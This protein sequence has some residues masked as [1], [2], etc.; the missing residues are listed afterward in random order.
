MKIKDFEIIVRNIL[1][2]IL[3]DENKYIELL[4][5]IGNNYKHDFKNQVSIYKY[6]K[7]ANTCANFDT[8]KKLHRKVIA[9]TKGIPAINSASKQEIKHLFDITQTIKNPLL[10]EKQIYI[11]KIKNDDSINLLLEQRNIEITNDISINLMNVLEYESL[12]ISNTLY[13]KLSNKEISKE[14]FNRFIDISLKATY[15][16]RIYKYEDLT[17]DKNSI[18]RMLNLL[19]I[20]D[21]FLVG[22]T[23]STNNKRLLL[24][25]EKLEK[26]AD[27]NEYIAYNETNKELKS[28]KEITHEDDNI[29][30]STKIQNERTRSNNDRSDNRGNTRAIA[31]RR[32]KIKR[33]VYK[34]STRIHSGVRVQRLRRSRSDSSQNGRYNTRRIQER[35]G[36]IW[37]G[38]I[39]ISSL[40]IHRGRLGSSTRRIYRWNTNKPSIESPK[41]LLGMDTQG[42]AKDEKIMGTNTTNASG[43]TTKVGGTI[44]QPITRTTFNGERY[45]LLYLDEYL[46]NKGNESNISLPFS[47]PEK[48]FEGIENYYY[49]EFEEEDFDIADL[50]PYNVGMA[51]TTTPDEKHEIQFNINLIDLTW[52][53]YVDMQKI[54][55]G[56]YNDYEELYQTIISCPFDE[57]VHINEDLLY[58]ETGLFIDDEGNFAED[59]IEKEYHLELEFTESK[60]LKTILENK[61]LNDKELAFII[62]YID[63]MQFRHKSHELLGGYYKTYIDIKDEKTGEIINHIRYDIGDGDT[64]NEYF[65]DVLDEDLKAKFSFT[66]KERDS[67]EAVRVAINHYYSRAFRLEN[68]YNQENIAQLEIIYDDFIKELNE[69]KVI[70]NE[71]KFKV[72]D[73]VIYYDKEYTIA[74]LDD[75]LEKGCRIELQDEVGYLDGFI[76]GSNVVYSNDKDNLENILTLKKEKQEVLDAQF[77]VIEDEK[78]PIDIISNENF[79][80]HE[81]ELPISLSISERINNNI[82]AINTLKTLEKETRNASKE[83][84]IFL[85]KYVGWGG[86]SKAFDENESGQW[87]EVNN[88]LKENLSKEEYKAAKE[89]TL[90]SFYTPQVVIDNIYQGLKNIGFNGGKILEPSC[91]VGNF[92]GSISSNLKDKTS[93]YGVELD[94]ITGKIAKYLYPKSNITITGFENTNFDDEYFEAAIGNVPF[95]DIKLYDRRYDKHNFLIHD[96]F[97]AKTIDKVKS[98]GVIAFI[99]SKGTLDKKDDSIR[100]YIGARCDLLG[101]IRLPNV[102]F[103]GTAGTEVV[104]DI[105]FLQKKDI[106]KEVEQDWYNLKTDSNGYTYNSYFVDNPKMVLGNIVEVSGRFGNELTCIESEQSYEELLPKA[107]ENIKGLIRYEEQEIDSNEISIIPTDD[108]KNFSYIA[109]DDEIYYRED[110]KMLN[111][112]VSKNN[113]EIVKSYI[114]L[115]NLTH[116]LLDIQLN[117]CTTIELEEAQ[118]ELNEKYDSFVSKYGYINSKKN[119]KLLEIDSNYPLIS[120]L[121]V[122]DENDKFDRKNDIFTKR[123]IRTTKIIDKVDSSSEALVVSINQKGKVDLDYMAKLSNIPKDKIIEELKGEIFLDIKPLVLSDKYL[124]A[125]SRNEENGYNYVTRDEYLSGNIREKI[126]TINKYIQ[127][128]ETVKEYAPSQNVD[129]KDIDDEIT[130]FKYQLDELTKVIPEKILAQDIS[131]RIGATWIPIEYYNEFMYELLDTPLYLQRENGVCISYSEYTNRFNI[132]NKKSDNYNLKATVNYGTSRINTYQIL[133]CLLNFKE[134]KITDKVRDEKGDK[135]TVVNEKETILA[136]QKAEIIKEEFKSWIFKDYDRRTKLENIYNETFNSIRNRNYDGSNLIFSGI[137]NEIELKEHQKNAIARILYG[138]NTLLAHVVGAGKT[139][140]MV[141]SAMESKRLGLINKP[142]FVVPN[143][144]TEQFGRE[145]LTLYPAANI[146]V[147]TKKDFEKGKRKKFTGRMAT[148]DYDAIIIGHSQFEKIPMSKEYQIEHIEKELASL[149]KALDDIKYSGNKFTVKQLERTIKNQRTQLEKLND[150][151]KKDDVIEFE[152]LGIDKLYIDEAHN[153]KNLYLYTKMTNIAGISTTNAF[154]SSDMYMKCRYMDTITDGKGICFATGTPVSNSMTELYTMQRYLQHDYL[155]KAG[156]NHFDS[157]AAAFGETLS[158]MELSPELKY[159]SKT[160]FSKFYNIPE[161]MQSFREVADIQTADMLDLPVPKANYETI[162][163]KPTTEQTKI[164][165]SFVTRAEKV[166]NGSVKPTEDNMLKITNDGKKLALDQRLINPMLPDNPKSKVN[167]CVDNIYRIWNDTKK[168]LSTQLVFSDMSTP[169]DDGSFNIYDDIKNKLINLG[170]P[171]DEIAFIH[172]AKTDKDKAKLFEKVRKGSVRVLLGSTQMMGAGTN[173]QDRLIALHDL[174][175]PWRPSDLEQRAG[176]IVRQGNNNDEVYVYRYVTENTFDSYLWQLIEHKQ[177]YI[178][179]IMTSKSPVRVA[180]D[181]DEVVLSYAEIKALATNNPLLKEKMDLDNDIVK[182]KIL[183]GS[184]K[185]TLYSLEDKIHNEYPT[186]IKKTKKLLDNQITDINHIAPISIDEKGNKVFSGIKINNKFYSDKDVAGEA[187]LK[188]I[189]SVDINKEINIG[190]Y[191]NFD[192]NVYYDDIKNQY[193]FKLKGENVHYGEFGTSTLGNFTRLDNCIDKFDEIK[194]NFERKLDNLNNQLINAKKQVS[195]PFDKEEELKEKLIRLAE[196]EEELLL[197]DKEKPIEEKKSLLEKASTTSKTQEYE[198]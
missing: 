109:I 153:Y 138:G 117:D 47:I 128:L 124:F 133:D 52:T 181:I 151:Y 1:E 179:Q 112:M 126:K 147:A 75:Y 99:T 53:Q 190:E 39:E 85:S 135:I 177:R 60:L 115:T 78:A 23:I 82:V 169:K 167:V 44:Q 62:S 144:L 176:R 55:S 33:R 136:K 70:E 40:H 140:E 25:T 101:A 132:S 107:I 92:I 91:G 22:D 134:I 77:E 120:N 158:T 35:I 142:L 32:R 154:K 64:L 95:G 98:G 118:K 121:E 46:D 191:R 69:E 170:I 90:T 106:I 49:E 184:Y 110:N 159:R 187:L 166:R 102:A 188:A 129:I 41:R 172:N 50:D 34:K 149:E 119:K 54:E 103:K 160:R 24:E 73:I 27:L 114:E 45:V 58:K 6:N 38:K 100:R 192:L 152:K 139:F 14:E 156:L 48:I 174:D 196:V 84:Q 194:L 43:R 87:L 36:S 59:T 182:L 81:N 105:I 96:Y 125:F 8:W 171:E 86:L 97:F 131:V 145:F 161:L 76:T 29:F 197:K 16:K 65:K 185:S 17:M 164:L 183:Q 88:Y 72:G 150:D 63:N 37:K 74:R 67:L 79:D 189:K 66:E 178:S 13:D 11:W 148:G 173:V 30:G 3:K 18:K 146:L 28:E 116:H 198:R 193:A 42:R 111:D 163:T 104:S 122:F 2:E 20:D 10:E 7:E 127:N 175:V 80:L 21:M 141:A 71:S 157:W 93:F 19:N 108:M 130:K 68:V 165:E 162:V 5:V 9:G 31:T 15:M 61:E 56:K 83:E 168:D 4:E 26:E 195:M 89:S 57:Y 94:S 123:T 137:N 113:K 143:H 186:S 180:D 12:K 51:Y 155:N